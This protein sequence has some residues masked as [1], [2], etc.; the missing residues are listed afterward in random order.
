MTMKKDMREIVE[1]GYEEGDYQSYYRL[2]SKLTRREK[3]FFT[4]LIDL[5]PEGGTI[6]DLGSGTGIPYDRFLVKRGFKVTG[7]DISSK[8]V[9]MARENVL[10][11]NYIKGDF[12]R[13]DLPIGIYDAVVSFYAVFHV[14]RNEHA[15][16]FKRIHAVLRDR[17]IIIV[18]MGVYDEELT[19]NDFIGSTMAWSS[20]PADKNLR[21]I[22]EAGFKLLL[23]E[24][25]QEKDEHHLWV[26]ARKG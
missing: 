14:P 13:I 8:H 1:K 7:I 15:E 12:T 6:L 3:R 10:G 17:G 18:T 22:E 9:K 5:I 21:I 20:F 11:A 4:K 23:V 19:I 16:L 25:Q 26:L 24:E 2:T